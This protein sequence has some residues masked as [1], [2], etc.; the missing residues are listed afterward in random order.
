[1][2]WLRLI[3][4]V[5]AS[6]LLV[7]LAINNYHSVEIHL[8]QDYSMPLYMIMMSCFFAGYIF[9]YMKR[10]AQN[11]VAYVYRKLKV[12]TTYQQQHNTTTNDD[13]KE[14]IDFVN[15]RTSN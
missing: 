5:I 10:V 9:G 4:T 8:W 11:V 15:G 7:L 13:T 2:K 6:F 12:K 14:L 3:I 1:M